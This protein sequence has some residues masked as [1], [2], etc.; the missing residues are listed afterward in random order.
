MDFGLR[1][2][3]IVIGVVVIAGILFDGWRRMSGGKGKLKFKLDRSLSELPDDEPVDPNLLGPVRVV[4]RDQEP[5]FD[6][7]DLPSFSAKDIN[8]R[9]GVEPRQGDLELDSE[10]PVPTLLTPVE[11]NAA[12]KP[13]AN[14]QKDLPPVEEVLVINVVARHPEGF[15]GPALLQSI[16]ESGLRF[17]EMDI[18]H[19]HESMAGN[20]EVLF[21]MANGVKPGTFDLDDM[22]LFSTRAVSFFLGLPGPR[23]PKQAFDLMV[24]AARK[25]SSELEGDLK[26]DQ[27]SVL[28]AQTIEHYR[29]R[30]VDFERKHMTQ[31]R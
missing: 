25:L 5:T 23:Y 14:S 31:K 28:T 26:D 1:E 13:A 18:F 10:E 20:G 9:R 24:A 15:K 11:E 17:G 2:W 30:I 29:Q 3:L 7:Q 21:S 19:R 27:R 4:K 6:E 12:A 16:L 22:D 8:K